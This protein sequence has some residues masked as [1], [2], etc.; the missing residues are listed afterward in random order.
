MFI[1]DITAAD[2]AKYDY[3]LGETGSVSCHGKRGV[4]DTFGNALYMINFMLHGASIGIKRFFFHNGICS[5]Y[6]RDF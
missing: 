1:P 5:F 6:L 3:V 4:S 2:A